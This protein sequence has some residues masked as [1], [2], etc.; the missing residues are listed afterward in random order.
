MG[1][2]ATRIDVGG[3][4]TNNLDVINYLY[5]TPIG[6]GEYNSDSLAILMDM[7]YTEAVKEE[8]QRI[9]EAS[10]KDSLNP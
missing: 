10:F 5:Q 7:S 8:L 4:A 2:F 9:R 1:A 3:F 6:V